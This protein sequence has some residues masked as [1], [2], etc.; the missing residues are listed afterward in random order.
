MRGVDFL[1][2]LSRP[3]LFKTYAKETQGLKL[4]FY[5]TAA[6]GAAAA[7]VTVAVAATTAG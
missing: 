4:R 1:T 6:T 2:L 3:V 7:A 5:F